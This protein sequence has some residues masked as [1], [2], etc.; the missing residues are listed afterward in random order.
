MP[1]WTTS[2]WPRNLNQ[3]ASGDP[4]AVHDVAGSDG[5]PSVSVAGSRPVAHTDSHRVVI[6]RQERMAT[7]RHN[8]RLILG[9]EDGGVNDLRPHRGIGS[10]RS[11]APL[12]HG[13]L[14]DTVASG[15]R[16][17]ALFNR[18]IAR[19]TAS[20]VVALPCRTWPI[21]PPAMRGGQA[22]YH[23]AELNT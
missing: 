7:K 2:P 12:L 17:Y 6:E 8:Y 5:E 1:Y 23:N 18:C 3:M 13:R 21:A 22:Y 16:P 10:M 14:T 11:P 20:I 9:G 4:G 19:R 15:E